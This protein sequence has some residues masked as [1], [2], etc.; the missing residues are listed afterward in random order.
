MKKTSKKK[1]GPFE[2]VT[3]DENKIVLKRA[4]SKGQKGTKSSE[5]KHLS[6]HYFD[7]EDYRNL[8]KLEKQINASYVPYRPGPFQRAFRFFF[9]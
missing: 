7:E 8:K 2:V 1:N 4:S 9:S 6:L 3:N 5:G